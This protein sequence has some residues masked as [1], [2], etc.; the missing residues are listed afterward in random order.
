[1]RWQHLGIIL[2]SALLAACSGELVVDQGGGGG[3][4]GGGVD[5]GGGGG[6]DADGGGDL[7]PAEEEFQTNVAPLFSADRPEGLTC[8]TCHAEGAALGAPYEFLGPNGASPGEMYEAI[9]AFQDPQPVIDTGA[10]A[11]SLVL[12]DP[13]HGDGGTNESGFAQGE[14]DMITA[15]LELE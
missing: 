14:K 15:W 3:G 6:G 7:T 11:N 5:A 1:M 9:K 4:G 2:A 12:V 10:P 13:A 8:V